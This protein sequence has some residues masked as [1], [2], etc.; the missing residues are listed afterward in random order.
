MAKVS[1]ASVV[2]GI[3][4]GGVD[5]GTEVMDVSNGKTEAFKNT[6]DWV[7]IG[8]LALGYLGQ[9]GGYMGSVA[10]PLAQSELPLVTKTVIRAIRAKMPAAVSS[11]SQPRSRVNPNASIGRSYNKEFEAVLAI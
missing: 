8:L 10:A 5:Y 1:V 3:A 2:V 11:V 4:V 7:R 9:V 6:T